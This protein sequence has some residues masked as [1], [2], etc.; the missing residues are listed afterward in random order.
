MDVLYGRYV[1]SALKYLES[2]SIARAVIK[3][4]SNANGE[5]VPV[6]MQHALKNEAKVLVDDKAILDC[7]DQLIEL[8]VLRYT[9]G[10][11][12]IFHSEL[13]RHYVL[14]YI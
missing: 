11:R 12:L 6:T 4:M 13:I 14:E 10:G 1:S 3:Y 2:S 8:D 9:R 5:I 7:I